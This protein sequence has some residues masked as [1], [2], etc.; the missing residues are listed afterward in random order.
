[1]RPNPKFLDIPNDCLC[2]T[3]LFLY[4]SKDYFEFKNIN[5]MVFECFNEETNLWASKNI[6]FV[7]SKKL[8]EKK[9]YVFILEYRLKEYTNEMD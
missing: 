4:S 6:I 9:E 3:C 5:K 8:P 7:L 2:H 1:M